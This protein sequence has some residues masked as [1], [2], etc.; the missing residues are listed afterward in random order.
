YHSCPT[1][2][3]SVASRAEC[4]IRTQPGASEGCGSNSKFHP[5]LGDR[6]GNNSE[7]ILTLGH[8]GRSPRPSPDIRSC[9]PMCGLTFHSGLAPGRGSEFTQTVLPSQI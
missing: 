6:S 3:F 1:D 4:L 5:L 2:G 9:G 7:A 8:N